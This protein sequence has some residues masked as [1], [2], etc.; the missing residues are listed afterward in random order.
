VRS[1]GTPLVGILYTTITADNPIV[2]ETTIPVKKV[3]LSLAWD[4]FE[5]ERD[6]I[7]ISKWIIE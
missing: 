5:G 6:S 3:A 7:F 1:G 2:S 4:T